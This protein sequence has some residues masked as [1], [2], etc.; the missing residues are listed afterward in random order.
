M[1]RCLSQYVRPLN[2]KIPLPSASYC[3][4]ETAALTLQ[5]VLLCASEA[6]FLAACQSPVPLPLSGIWRD[7]FLQ[8]Q[9]WLTGRSRWQGAELAM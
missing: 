3:E 1:L 8:Q 7:S 9:Q 4:L 2:L 5:R 6:H